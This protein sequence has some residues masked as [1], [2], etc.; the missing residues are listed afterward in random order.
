MLASALSMVF[1][2]QS[3]RK[4]P[5]PDSIYTPLDKISRYAVDAQWLT[6]HFEK[7]LSD[8]AQ[9]VR[10][11]LDGWRLTRE[12]RFKQ[13]IEETLEYVRRELTHPDGGFYAAQDADS[14]GY[15]GK[16]FV[17]EPGKIQS[18]LG[19]E[20]GELFCRVYR[21][22]AGGNFE[23]KSILNRLAGLNLNP[24]D[25][26]E[27]EA[28][29]APA[30]RRLWEVRER[31]VKPER[32]EKILTSWNGLM[33][34]GLLDAYQIFGIPM[35]LD[36]AER[37]LAFLL[38]RVRVNGRLHRTV[39]GGQARLNGYL[40]DYAFLAAALIDAYEATSRR[41]YLERAV[42][43]TE[44]NYAGTVLGRRD[45]RLFLH[46]AGSRGADSTDEVRN[47]RRHAV[48]QRSRGDKSA[49]AVFLCGRAVL[50]GPSRPDAPRLSRPDGSKRAWL[51]GPAVG[52]GPFSR[53]AKGDR[54]GGG[55]DRSSRAGA[56]EADLRL[57]YSEQDTHRAGERSERWTGAGPGGGR[58]KR[59]GER[60]ADRL[61]L[62]WVHLLRA[63]DGMG[64][65]AAVA[66]NNVRD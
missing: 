55:T 17:W 31:R 64:G 24:E 35:Y 44:I 45:G 39:T 13:V 29:L 36:M 57:L 50:L 37:S 51:G 1:N 65:V 42:E 21:V 52:A 34:S 4:R 38:E 66:G 30:K 22:T 53:E 7:M 8:N 2:N 33:V 40:D 48:R 14:E 15:E 18:I 6:P 59:R 19:P 41:L 61:R 16:F 26:E 46:R 43:L 47:R 23:G 60:Q 28:I 11:Y 3:R 63:C 27:L 62:S 5:P 32:D 54:V 56:A 20:L 9:L 25:Q 49:A 58:R 10:I 12:V